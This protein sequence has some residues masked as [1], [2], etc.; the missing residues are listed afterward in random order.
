MSMFDD[1]AK[2]AMGAL[3]GNNSGMAA[4]V[5]HLLSQDQGGIGGL[6]QKFE[7]AGMGDMIKGW[8]ST[9]P[10]PAV[11]PAELSSALGPDTVS[12]LAA[13]SGLNPQDLLSQLSAHLPGLIDKL[14]PNGA[15][16]SGDALQQGLGG[17][18]GS[19]FGK[20]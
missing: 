6:V 17:M 20:H 15:A 16:P 1:L 2:G 12:K 13:T 11:S 4:A 5:S 3:G 10:N 7:Q 9:G 18:L 14:T 8:I 19:L